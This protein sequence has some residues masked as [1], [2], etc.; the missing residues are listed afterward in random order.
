MRKTPNKKYRPRKSWQ[1]QEITPSATVIELYSNY[2]QLMGVA[3]RVL[4]E[5]NTTAIPHSLILP[6]DYPPESPAVDIGHGVFFW[7]YSLVTSDFMKKHGN[8]IHY[9]P[10]R[11]H[12]LIIISLME[13]IFPAPR[14]TSYKPT[15]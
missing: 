2:F 12:Y 13:T 6:S 11:S 5:H 9:H 3:T 15:N 4:A 7:Y 1:K 14:K 10:I 8:L